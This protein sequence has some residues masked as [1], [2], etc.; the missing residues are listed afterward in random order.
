VDQ[1]A[2]HGRGRDHER[3]SKHGGCCSLNSRHRCLRIVDTHRRR[4]TH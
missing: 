1:P 3:C 2:A 4:R